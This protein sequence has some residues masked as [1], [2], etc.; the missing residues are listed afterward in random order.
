MPSRALTVRTEYLA[1]DLRVPDGHILPGDESARSPGVRKAHI[2]PRL[3]AIDGFKACATPLRVV[4]RVDR[5]AIRLW[6]FLSAECR[7]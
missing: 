1:W 2:P 5:V 4:V 7:C 6:A 3:I